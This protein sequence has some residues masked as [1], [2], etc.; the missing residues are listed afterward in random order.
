L[1]TTAQAQSLKPTDD[2]QDFEEQ[3]TPAQ[4]SKLL[5]SGLTSGAVIKH[6]QELQDIADDNDGNRAS[7]SSGYNKSASYVAKTL[8]GY[9]WDVS[10]EK[11]DFDAFFQDAPST[12][13]RTR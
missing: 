10:R 5:R 7:G 1:I 3:P 4:F 6:L 2:D 13:E 9:G 11:F 12:F 8:K